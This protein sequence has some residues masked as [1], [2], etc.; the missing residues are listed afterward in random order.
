ML[1][2][3]ERKIE[4]TPYTVFSQVPSALFFKADFLQI[5]LFVSDNLLQILVFFTLI[6]FFFSYIRVRLQ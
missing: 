5:F 1:Q 4:K 2:L 6:T 3:K